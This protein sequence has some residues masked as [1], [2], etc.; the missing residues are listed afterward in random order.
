MGGTWESGSF[1]VVPARKPTPSM[2]TEYFSL[3]RP[4]IP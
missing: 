3:I 2:I 4:K 1:V